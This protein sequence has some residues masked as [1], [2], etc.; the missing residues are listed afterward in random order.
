MRLAHQPAVAVAALAEVEGDAGHAAPAH[1]VERARAV[2]R[3]SGRACRPSTAALRDGEE[4]HALDAGRR[5]VDA[6]QGEVDDVLGE[7][8]VAA[9]DEDLGARDEVVAVARRRRPRL[10]VGE[11][12]CRPGA[13]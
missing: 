1:L 9:G 6:R 12:R 11:A 3:R 2:A 7:V 8:V 4:R 13:R 5:A 10:H